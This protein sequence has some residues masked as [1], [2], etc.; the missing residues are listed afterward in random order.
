MVVKDILD[1]C[2]GLGLT[3]DVEVGCCGCEVCL[4]AVSGL[5]VDVFDCY[6][7]CVMMIEPFYFDEGS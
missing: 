4:I 5:V 3:F 2:G 6:L 7:V 1:M